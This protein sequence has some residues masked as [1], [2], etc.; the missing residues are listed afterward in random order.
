MS[1]RT[2]PIAEVRA[3]GDYDQEADIAEI[4]GHEII[5][6][7]R[8]TWRW[9]ENAFCAY[10]HDGAPFYEGSDYSQHTVTRRGRLDLNELWLD[11]HAGRFPIED[12]MRFYMG[13]GYSLCGFGEVFGQK[14]AAEWKLPGARTAPK[15]KYGYAQTLL[16]YVIEKHKP[17]GRKRKPRGCVTR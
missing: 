9:K 11:F 1:E 5:E 15:D 12:L 16:D 3:N 10:L 7:E 8:G 6:T 4:F 13:L 14:E 17:K 2:I